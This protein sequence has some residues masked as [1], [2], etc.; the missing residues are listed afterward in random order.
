[1]NC[2]SFGKSAADRK[3]DSVK[4]IRLGMISVSENRTMPH[5]VFVIFFKDKYS[6]DALWK[7]IGL[8]MPTLVDV[9]K[10]LAELA[11]EN[12]LW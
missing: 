1:M 3:D 10:T 2:W 6:L 12:G 4:G 5:A 8:E 11:G 7:E 9:Q